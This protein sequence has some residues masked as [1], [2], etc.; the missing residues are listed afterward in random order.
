MTKGNH[1]ESE[2]IRLPAPRYEPSTS[3]SK[4]D[5]LELCQ[6]KLRSCRTRPN[7]HNM[8]CYSTIKAKGK[9]VP[10]LN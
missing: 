8:R 4:Y 7:N 5:P 3:I 1:K 10:L 9:V 6:C 2:N